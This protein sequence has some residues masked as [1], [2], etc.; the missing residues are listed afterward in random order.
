MVM[1]GTNL[2][3][4]SPH[5]SHHHQHFFFMHQQANLAT[6]SQRHIE[7]V[8]TIDHA[9]RKLIDGPD[10]VRVSGRASG[11]QPRMLVPILP[12]QVS[13]GEV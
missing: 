5:S 9:W 2:S 12:G 4:S 3:L 10:S 11:T 13:H 8:S 7:L 1:K 6:D